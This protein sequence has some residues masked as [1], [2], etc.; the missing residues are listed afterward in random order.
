MSLRSSAVDQVCRDWD[1]RVMFEST[2][3]GFV[4]VK[5]PCDAWIYQEM[6][7]ELKPDVIIETGTFRS[8]GALF[9]ASLCDLVGNGKVI[10]F[11]VRPYGENAKHP[12]ITYYL[13]NSVQKAVVAEVKATLKDKK[14]LVILD[15]NHDYDHVIKELNTWYDVV[16][17][18]SYIIVEDTWWKPD[19]GG[20]Y[21]AVQEFLKEHPEFE[22]D[23]SREKWLMTNNPMGYLKRNV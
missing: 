9:L 1:T 8:G 15:S 17:K 2:W 14:V 11:D 18:G 19:G 3:L 12:R 21:Q 5:N 16:P 4:A 7:F 23:K 6:I 22:I 10:T 20:P 13:A